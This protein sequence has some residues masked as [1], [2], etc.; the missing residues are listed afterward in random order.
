M[1]SR[2]W[3]HRGPVFRGKTGMRAQQSQFRYLFH[4]ELAC[5]G[6]FR[7]PGITPRQKSEHPEGYS[8]RRHLGGEQHQ[9]QKFWDYQ[10]Q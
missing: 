1:V 10:I 3:N 8:T 6:G 7:E 4:L 5:E 2:S 9:E